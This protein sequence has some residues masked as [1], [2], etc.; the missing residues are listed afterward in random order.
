MNPN[1]KT[2]ETVSASPI[3]KNISM[4]SFDIERMQDV[5]LMVILTTALFESDGCPNDCLFLNVLPQ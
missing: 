4:T 3:N 2:N 5:Q 1:P